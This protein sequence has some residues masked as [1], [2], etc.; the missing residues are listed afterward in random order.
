[1]HNCPSVLLIVTTYFDSYDA[2]CMCSTAVDE[3]CLQPFGC[4]E[5]LSAFDFSV[6]AGDLMV[7]LQL[8]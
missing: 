7:A 5:V 1:M 2:V 3:P 4:L 8:D 6:L